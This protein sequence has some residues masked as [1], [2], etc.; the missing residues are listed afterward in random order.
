MKEFWKT[1]LALV[2]LAALGSYLWFVE[3]KKEIKP[4][5]ERDKVTVLAVDKTKAREVEI[6]SGGDAL[7]VT[8]DGAGWKVVKPFTAPADASAVDSILSSLEKVEADEVVTEKAASL[9]DF[10]LDKP[11]RT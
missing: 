4:E 2:V 1:G 5:G 6:V 7:K 8:K 11:S 9:T 3:R 10:G